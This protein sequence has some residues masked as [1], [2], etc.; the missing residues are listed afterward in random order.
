MHNRRLGSL[1]VLFIAALGS[2]ALLGCSTVTGGIGKTGFEYK[3]YGY[4]VL[5]KNVANRYFIN[6]G[7]LIDNFYASDDGGWRLKQGRSYYGYQ[8][9][10]KEK[11]GGV[12]KKK[13]YFF[14]LKLNHRRT[15]AVIWVQSFKMLQKHSEKELRVLLAN[16][17]ESLTGSGLY[18]EGNVYGLLRI[19]QK[20]KA[21]VI[22]ST[23]RVQVQQR[24]ALRARLRIHNL[25]RLKVDPKHSG[26]TVEILLLRIWVYKQVRVETTWEMRTV[27]YPA[28][29]VIGYQSSTGNF[30]RHLPDFETFLQ[31]FRFKTTGKEKP[32]AGA[33]ARNA[34]AAG[35]ARRTQP[36]PSGPPPRKTN[37]RPQPASQPRPTDPPPVRPPE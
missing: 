34:G 8:L 35:P 37:A 30:E 26:K 1:R 28:I 25:D 24:Q 3:D 11:V 23:R 2:C 10:E 15:N 27:R 13:V 17:V 14:D 31:Q 7:W 29:M 18:A 4:R 9:R 32:S 20:K 33:P 36:Q 21:A 12:E 5:Y 22:K 19:K 6:G 16:Y